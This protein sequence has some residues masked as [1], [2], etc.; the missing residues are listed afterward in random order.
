MALVKTP[1][2][3]RTVV[4]F[5]KPHA[6]ARDWR[7]VL[8]FTLD[9]PVPSAIPGAGRYTNGDVSTL[10]WSYTLSTIPTLLRDGADSPVSKWYTV[11]STDATP[12]PVLPIACP[13]LALYLQAALDESRRATGDAVV[14]PKKLARMVESCYPN[15]VRLNATEE[16]A[17]RRSM[18]GRLLAKF[19]K[20]TKAKKGRG[21]GNEETFELVT[22][23]VPDEWG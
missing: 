12:Y 3:L 9:H 5:V 14:G 20:G 1:M 10:P 19:G 8:W 4:Q 2:K 16:P 21:G 7:T 17:D 18:G 11:P 22:P 13:N 6:S 15:D 23:F